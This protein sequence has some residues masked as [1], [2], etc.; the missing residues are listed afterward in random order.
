VEMFTLEDL[1]TTTNLKKL[2]KKSG[3]LLCMVGTTNMDLI[4]LLFH[5]SRSG[6]LVTNADWLEF[7]QDGGYEKKQYW[8]EEGWGWVTFIQPK[9]ALFWV[10]KGNSFVLRNFISE[11]DSMPWDWPVEVNTLE[12]NA[13]CRWC[14]DK[15]G[16]YTRLPTEDEW[17]LAMNQNSPYL[18]GTKFEDPDEFL[19][20]GVNIG[21]KFASSTPVDMHPTGQLFDVCGNV[22]QWTKTPTYPFESFEVHPIYLDFTTPTYDDKHNTIKGGSWVTTGNE[23]TRFSR[24]AFRRH[25]FQFAGFRF[26]QDGTRGN[27]F[28][29]E[30]EPKNF[31]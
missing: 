28:E 26:V 30:Y 3:I 10:P 16:V 15:S 18:K 14:S 20:Q 8:S 6:Q 21:L 19:P 24:Y 4:M 17:N 2:I 22:W 1:W 23:A 13:Y 25:F 27:G 9:H 31:V 7:I 5:R 11:T 29:P 12:A